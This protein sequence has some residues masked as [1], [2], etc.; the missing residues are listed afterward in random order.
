MQG[1]KITLSRLLVANP[2]HLLHILLFAL[3]SL[4]LSVKH[5]P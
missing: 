4:P 5:G 3:S 2:D 1:G